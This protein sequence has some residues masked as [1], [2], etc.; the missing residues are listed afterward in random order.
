MQAS[1]AECEP[2]TSSDLMSIVLNRSR[3]PWGFSY[4]DVPQ[5]M[6]VWWGTEDERISS[7]SIRWLEST[8]GC[9]VRELHGEG[10]N[11]M[12]SGTVL[13][14]VFGA[15]RKERKALEKAMLDG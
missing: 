3:R 9:E 14:D 7:K 1:H 6:T 5:A 2:G 8:T 10:H 15:I 13:C 11:L 12:T 4:A